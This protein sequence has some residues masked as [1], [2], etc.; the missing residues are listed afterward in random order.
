VKAKGLAPLA[1]KTDKIDAWVLAELA[2]LDLVPE[3]W[4][5]DPAVRAERERARFRLHLVKHR[6]ALKNRVHSTLIAHGIPNPTSDL[7]GVGGR[8]LLERVSL[9]EPWRSTSA[10]TLA[11]LDLLDEQIVACERELRSLGADHPYVPLLMSCPGI[12]WI[13]AFTIASEIGDIARFPTSTKLVGYSGL[14]PRVEQS[15]D[16]DRRG[17]L[18]KNGPNYL[19]W[20]LVEAAHTASRHPLYRP[21]LERSRA[22]HGRKRGTKIAALTIARKLAHS[23]WHMLTRDEPFAPAGATRPLVA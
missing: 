21:I 6:T 17:P 10:A 9:P 22:R 19:R 14:T 20:A 7:F 8:R 4:L 15:G 5:P 13:L 12:A 16:S 2:R 23:I 18:R 1:C 3:I 11:L